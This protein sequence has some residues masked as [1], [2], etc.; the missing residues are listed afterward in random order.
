M[1]EFLSGRSEFGGQLYNHRDNY[2]LAAPHDS[3]VS[4]GLKGGSWVVF[5][6]YIASGL[7]R[8][9][10]VEEELLYS[11][12]V[13]LRKEGHKIIHLGSESDKRSDLREYPFVD[14]DLRGKLSLKQLLNLVVH[15]SVASTVTYDNFF[16]HLFGML[17]KDA[18]VLFRGRFT[19]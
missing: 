19:K 3:E 5:N 12:C 4:V 10:F 7:F 18:H 9:F 15:P 14:Y 8:K 1:R 6:N 16:M 2:E 13:Q 11:K 17:G